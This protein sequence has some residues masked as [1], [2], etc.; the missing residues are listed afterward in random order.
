VAL[1]VENEPMAK[2]DAEGNMFGNKNSPTWW[3]SLDN[4]NATPPPDLD[5]TAEPDWEWIQ[6]G[7][8][9][10][11]HEHRIHFM[12]A[13]IDPTIEDGAD[14][15]SFTLPFLVD[16]AEASIVGALVF[17]PTL[18]PE[19]AQRLREG[20]PLVDETAELVAAAEGSSSGSL[21]AVAVVGVI[22]VAFAAGAVVVLRRRA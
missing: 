1:G 3:L 6:A 5:V 9:L 19:G 13:G 8:S 15:F 2:L 16:G 4:G 21:V 20:K 22:V 7:G 18:D 10:Q 11:Y 17:D 14:V 12:A